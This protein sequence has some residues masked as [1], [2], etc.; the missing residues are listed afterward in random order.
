MKDSRTNVLARARDHEAKASVHDSP[1]GIQARLPDRVGR[2]VGCSSGGRLLP[3]FGS[4]VGR[5]FGPGRTCEPTLELSSGTRRGLLRVPRLY[6]P[7]TWRVASGMA[8]LR[9]TGREDGRPS[10]PSILQAKSLPAGHGAVGGG[11]SLQ[12]RAY[13]APALSTAGVSLPAH[14]E[15][16][17]RISGNDPW[18]ARGESLMNREGGSASGRRRVLWRFADV[19]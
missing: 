10:S 8:G 5:A 18:P 14:G 4:G 19:P 2:V 7:G 1:S 17:Q 16:P 15:E 9:G 13:H 6:P 3:S 11:P 12:R